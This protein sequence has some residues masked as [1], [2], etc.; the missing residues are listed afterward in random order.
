M[1]IHSGSWPRIVFVAA[2]AHFATAAS[3]E[4]TPRL[5]EWERGFGLRVPGEPAAEMFL[6]IYE[7][8]MFEAMTAGQHTKGTYELPRRLAPDGSEAVVD[9]PQFK[10]TLRPV[11]DGAELALRVTN[12]TSHAWPETAGII[13]CWNPGQVPGTNP[14]MPKP[15]NPR[16]SDPWRR[17]TYYVSRGGLTPLDSRAIHFNAAVRAAAD[18]SA[19]GGRFAWSNKWPTSEENATA[20]LIVRESEDGRWVTGVAWQDFVSVQGHNPWYC[21]HNCVRVGPLEP[22][23]SR[24]V[25]GRLYLFPGD[26]EECLARFQRDF[27]SR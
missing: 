8:N 3:A 1:N 18:R 10:L 13:P 9:A 5:F 27:P 20:G 24:T 6:W 12:R 21:M 26:K 14:S 2:L 4:V 19:E 23:K 11:A 17:N 25:R 7:W 22:G 15:L 16:F